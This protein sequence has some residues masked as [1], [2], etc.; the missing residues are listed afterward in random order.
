MP[1]KSSVSPS[2]TCRRCHVLPSSSDFRITPLE[3]EAQ[4]TGTGTP[5][6]SGVYAALTAR[7]SVSMPLVCTFHQDFSAGVPTTRKSN[8]AK[9]KKAL[10]VIG[11]S[12]ASVCR[13][14]HEDFYAFHDEDDAAHGGDVLQGVAIEGD[15]VGVESGS[16]GAGASL[17][18]EGFGRERVGGN[19]CSHGVLATGLHTI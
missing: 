10:V 6:V 2:L 11:G 9:R 16:D 17:D 18:T 7:R 5:F 14:V 3:P 12:F 8:A 13:L 4:T 1:R 15:D 19:H